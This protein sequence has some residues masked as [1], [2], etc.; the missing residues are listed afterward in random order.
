MCRWTRGQVQCTP[1]SFGQAVK[2][3]FKGGAQGIIPSRNYTE[4]KPAN[5]SGAGAAL[6]E[7]GCYL[8]YFAHRPAIIDFLKSVTPIELSHSGIVVEHIQ[9]QRVKALRSGEPFDQFQRPGT[10]ALPAI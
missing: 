1:K 9:N 5:L 6:R 7:F 10:V 4:M 3:A 2:A 8:E